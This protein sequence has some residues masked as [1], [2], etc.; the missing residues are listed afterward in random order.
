MYLH[1]VHRHSSWTNSMQCC[2]PSSSERLNNSRKGVL[3]FFLLGHSYLVPSSL[4]TPQV[5]EEVALE[6]TSVA[7]KKFL[8]W[9]ARFH[10]DQC[11]FFCVRAV[12]IT[13]TALKRSQWDRR[14]FITFVVFCAKSTFLTLYPYHLSSAV[15]VICLHVT[16]YGVSVERLEI[17]LT[18]IVTL[19]VQMPLTFVIF[20][21]LERHGFEFTI[22]AC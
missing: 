19:L 21:I 17:T 7:V 4:M 18:T 6:L 1:Q 2:I 9:V 14:V 20:H 12:E 16:P 22:A 3:Q 5:V 15:T 10:V 13:M 11:Q 8:L